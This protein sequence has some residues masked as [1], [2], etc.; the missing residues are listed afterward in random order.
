MMKRKLSKN[1]KKSWILEGFVGILTIAV[2]FLFIKFGFSFIGAMGVHDFFS[3]HSRPI[4]VVFIILFTVSFIGMAI[5]PV[6]EY[7]QWSYMINDDEI[8]FREGIFWS[9]EVI[10]PIVR[11]QNINLKENPI[12][13]MLGIADICIGTA[14]GVHKIPAIDKSEVEVI[15]KFLREKVNENVKKENEVSYGE[16]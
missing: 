1:A 4:N 8:W 11:I 2:I 16:K 10:V 13:K 12:S 6:F 7:K 15:M 5:A 9:K 3:E 14:G